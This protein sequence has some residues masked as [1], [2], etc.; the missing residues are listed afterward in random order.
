M[1]QALEASFQILLVVVIKDYNG[2]VHANRFLKNDYLHRK[3]QSQVSPAGRVGGRTIVE[4][5]AL[6]IYGG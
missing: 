4:L 3:T 6:V 2:D 5:P 1:I